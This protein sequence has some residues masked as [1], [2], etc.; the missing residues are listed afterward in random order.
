MEG[1]GIFYFNNGNREMGDYLN[2]K[3]VGKHAKLHA[4]GNVTANNY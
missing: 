2:D 1:K 4:N 3:K